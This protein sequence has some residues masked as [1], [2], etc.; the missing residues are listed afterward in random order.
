[1]KL[2]ECGLVESV[3]HAELG[4]EPL[5]CI[6]ILSFVGVIERFAEIEVPQVASRG[7]ISGKSH[8]QAQSDELANRSHR[9]PIPE[10]DRSVAGLRSGK[11]QSD[12]LWLH[13]LAES[14]LFRTAKIRAAFK[15]AVDKHVQLVIP[16]RHVADV[17][18]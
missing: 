7:R 17:D 5:D 3:V 12:H 2:V 1:M 4:V 18:S 13:F 9:L 8:G 6:E 16:G 15:L 14:K 11:S 10:L